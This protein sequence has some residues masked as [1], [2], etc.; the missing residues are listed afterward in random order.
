MD[1][2][3]KNIPGFSGYCVDDLGNVY[4]EWVRVGLS[5]RKGSTS[6]RS[7]IFK[8][9][10]PYVSSDGYLRV[11]LKSDDGKVKIRFVHV[12]VALCFLGEKPNGFQVCHIDGNRKNPSVSN[13]KYGTAKENAQDRDSHGTTARGE[14]NGN[15]LLSINDVMEIRR[16]FS[17]GEYPSEII[18]SYRVSLS[19]VEDICYQRSWKS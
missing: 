19:C 4:S 3:L 11:N 5:G 10:N 8:K 13:L 16:R 14:R 6:V 1:L 18:K 17:D 12:L 15:A 9:L 7:G 2:V